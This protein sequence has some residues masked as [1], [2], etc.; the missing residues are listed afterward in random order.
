[1]QREGEIVTR[2]M[3]LEDIWKFHFIP[4]TNLVDVHIGRLRHKLDEA[5]A[6]PMIE[7]VRGVGFIFHAAG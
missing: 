7:S 6:P 1:M 4:Q 5:A 3:L 2:A